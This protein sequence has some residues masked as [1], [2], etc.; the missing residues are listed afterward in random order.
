MGKPAAKRGDRVFGFDVHLLQFPGVP[1]PIPIPLPFMGTLSGALSPNVKIE[2]KPAAKFGTTVRN[3]PP[4]P[5]VLPYVKP[6]TNQGRAFLCS[7]RVFINML[8][9]ARV[10]DLVL[11]CSD[12]VDLPLTVV[13]G[14]S[15]V[16]I[17]D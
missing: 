4:H 14:R 6:P 11:T 10:G 1:S 17:G 3:T 12:P 16:R 8:P 15:R 5:P 9:A 13:L 7:F 2:G